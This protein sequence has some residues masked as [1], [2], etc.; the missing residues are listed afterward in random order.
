MA[1]LQHSNADF[2]ARIQK[3]FQDLWGNGPLD[4]GLVARREQESWARRY[5]S[6]LPW[7]DWFQSLR[8]LYL[9]GSVSLPKSPGVLSI[10]APAMP[11]GIRSTDG[12]H[13]PYPFWFVE[14]DDLDQ[15]HR[16]F[17]RKWLPLQDGL[18]Y[19]SYVVVQDPK[20]R[21]ILL[22]TLNNQLQQ[23]LEAPLPSFV[24]VKI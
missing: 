17:A 10:S 2:E 21:S 12:M 14:T 20:Q 18:R 16:I 8:R 22:K 1:Q 4:W 7:R 5:G 23:E 6:D 3:A 9:L 11:F 19:V 13:V 24:P 15:E